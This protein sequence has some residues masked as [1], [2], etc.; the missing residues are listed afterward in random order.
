MDM[1]KIITAIVTPQNNDVV[2]VAS[3][4]NLIQFQMSNHISAL[5][6]L[7]TTGEFNNMSLADKKTLLDGLY[8]IKNSKQESM[9]LMICISTKTH[10]ETLDIIEYCVQK[11]YNIDAFVVAP[12]FGK[13]DPEEKVRMILQH[14]TAPLMLYNNPRIH[15][16]AN[17]PI[18][19]VRKFAAHPQIIGIKDSSGNQEYLNSLLSL[20]S[21]QFHIYQ[22]AENNLIHDLKN[23][24]LT[25]IISGSANIIP[26][27]FHNLTKNI[28]ID[29]EQKHLATIKSQLAKYSNYIQ[30]IKLMLHDKNILASADIFT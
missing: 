7:G 6:A 11:K 5:L 18:E 26:W 23:L 22:G 9:F 10:S 30:G 1:P 17:I 12:L 28:I 21:A 2:D 14:T 19:I 16:E 29:S 4:V 15:G 20:A 13:N 27:V 3:L 8:K 24:K 25:G